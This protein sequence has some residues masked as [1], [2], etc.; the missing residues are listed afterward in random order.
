M[1]ES[2][3][4]MVE[5]TV[6]KGEIARYEQFLLFP[7]C[8]QK[9]L[10]ADTKKPG[11]VW[12]RVK[13]QIFSMIQIENIC[14]ERNRWNLKQILFGIGRKYSIACIQRPLKGSNE[15][16]LLQQVVFKYRF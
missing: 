13:Q 5:N 16:G 10:S 4:K 2:A 15:S 7:H 11:F 1:T 9:T 6:G 12:Q 14:R 8:F 3:S